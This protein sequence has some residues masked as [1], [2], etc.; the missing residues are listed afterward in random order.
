MQQPP[1]IK[2]AHADAKRPI[3]VD[4][5][6]ASQVRRL[7]LREYERRRWTYEI[8][9]SMARKRVN[10]EA[11]RFARFLETL[12]DTIHWRAR[13]NRINTRVVRGLLGRIA[14]DTAKRLEKRCMVYLFRE[15]AL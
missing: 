7:L 12:P 4:A 9:A 15:N 6:V 13:A 8:C 14:D 1:N 10:H 5:H 3:P 2:L 11:A